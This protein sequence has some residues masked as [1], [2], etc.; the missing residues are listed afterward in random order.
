MPTSSSRWAA[1][2]PRIIPA[3]S[4]GSSRR[5]RPAA[6]SSSPSTR[7]SRARR[8]SPTSTPRSAPGSDIAFLLGII[9]Y[10]IETKR[11][12]EE[13]V[14]LHTNAP[15]LISEKYGFDEGL[16]S[17]F[18]EAAG[19]YDKTTWA[20]EADPKTKAYARRPDARESALRL[21]APEEARRPLHAGDGRADLRNAEGHVP[22][23]L[24]D[25]DLDGQRRAGAAR[26]PTPSA[27]RS[28]RRA[29]R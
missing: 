27:G 21:P 13:Y 12:H 28:T 10:A 1:I 3:V 19:T 6:P 22:E 26:S 18:D 24:R 4:S 7:A 9:R 2:P 29:S 16:F 23:G 8:P 20:Y 17:G 11:F 14:K 5:R 25:R 15:Y